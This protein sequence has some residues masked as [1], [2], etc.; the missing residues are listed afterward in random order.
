MSISKSELQ[1]LLRRFG[2]RS[3]QPG[4]QRAIRGLLDSRDILAVLPT[5]A[6]KS[7]VYQ[8]AAQLLPGLTLVVSPLIA[9][10]QD[11]EESLEAR[12]L[13]V[14]VMNS[15]RS[16]AQSEDELRRAERG[17]AKL[18]YVTPER[19][20]DE[21]FVER[22]GKTKIS[23]LVVDEA[24]CIS[25][26]GHDFR[27][28]YL[29]L[30]E[31]ARRLRRP[32]ILALTATATPWVRQEILERLDMHEPDIIV[33]GTDRPNLVFEV[34][35]V[36]SEQEEHR[37][38]ERLFN[39]EEDVEGDGTLAEAEQPPA[40]MQG[41]GIV[42]TATT[43]AARETAQRLQIWGIAA[44][45]YHGQRRKSDRERVQEAFMAGR[46]RIV[47]ATN[48][49][50]LGI[51]KPDVRFV[52][53]LD[54]PAS[55]EAYYQEAGRAGRDGKPARCTLIYRPADLGRAAFLAAGG[56]LSED[57]VRRARKGLL[58][59][60]QGSTK[61]LVEATGLSKGDLARLVP[62][63]E[64]AGIV[65]QKRGR[66]RLRVADFDPSEISLESEERR[67]AYERSRLDMMRGYAELRECRRRYILNY[68]GEEYES[69]RCRHCDNDLRNGDQSA[70]LPDHE[71]S[72]KVPFA[73]ND[74]VTHKSWGEGL[75]QRVTDESIV[76]L[77]DSVGYKTLDPEIATN[78]GALRS[79]RA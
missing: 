33:R 29:S 65:E 72:E 75:I 21:A 25:E 51:D 20:N 73:V 11:Q 14:A 61:Q 59:I 16:E 46:I 56:Q 26:W 58:K 54:V 53:H 47:A 62:L 57:D 27:P 31:V 45:Y 5:G 79:L 32:T 24:H 7:L 3:F 10:M 78:G 6:G 38:L 55:L 74:R 4:Q 9:L 30:G 68:F 40:L 23:L 69:D 70:S 49:F 67:R 44:D 35:R 19:L 37:L 15:A 12:G 66:V 18:L 34:R 13:D 8:L 43:K 41:P 42:Y 50:G 64:R 1:S 22:I 39:G 2:H 60:R 63:L 77:F 76:V 17:D 71:T 28:S 48:A 52:L 36:D